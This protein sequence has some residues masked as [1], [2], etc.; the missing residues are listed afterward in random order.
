MIEN[1]RA[2]LKEMIT[3]LDWM[4]KTTK[5]AAKEKVRRMLFYHLLYSSKNN[6]HAFSVR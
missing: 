5:T 4:G 3:D 1:L 2:S 6:S